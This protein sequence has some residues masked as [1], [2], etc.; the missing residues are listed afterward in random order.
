[1]NRIFLLVIAF[2]FVVIAASAQHNNKPPYSNP[3]ALIDTFK[4][5]IS[6]ITQGKIGTTTVTI[7]YYSPGVKNRIIWG[8]L[9]P[10]NQ[11]W[12]T[13]AHAATNI[14]INKPFVIGSKKI[15]AGTYAIFTIPGKSEWVFI[16]N[17][18]HEQHLTDEY[19]EEEDLVRLK[20]KPQPIIKQLERLQYFIEKGKLVIAWEK[21][22]VEV[23]VQIKD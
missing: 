21:L 3:N 17:K 5:S 10:Y 16:L 15:P 18:N 19:K 4:K 8:G 23:P 20:V 13:G 22:K 6:C 14:T 11:V 2:L 9:V 7:R 1:M 12:V